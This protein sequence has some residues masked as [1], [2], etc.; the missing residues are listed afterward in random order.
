MDTRRIFVALRIRPLLDNERYEP[1]CVHKADDNQTLIVQQDESSVTTVGSL[2][3]RLDYVFDVN[4][5]QRSVYEDSARDL[6]DHALSGFNSTIFAYGQTGSGKTYTILGNLG[7]NGTVSEQSGVLLRTFNDLFQYKAAVK[8]RM[9]V[10]IT[11]SALELYVED[12][13]DLL[14]SRK[15]LT[16]R[17][18]PEDMYPAGLTTVEVHDLTE[19]VKYFEIANSFRSTASTRM[20]A[21]S[22]RSHAIFF[23]NLF[24]IPNLEDGGGGTALPELS[25]LIDEASFPVANLSFPGL[26]RS[27]IALVDL[28]GS[29]R[30]KRS[31]VQGQ[32]MLEAE[33]INKSL[34]TLGKVVNAMYM[35]SPYVPFRESKLTK[36]L[37]ASFTDNTSRMLLIGQVSP[38]SSSAPESLS[39]VRFC[40]RV[41]SLKLTQ[42]LC[43]GNPEEEESFLRSL[44]QNEE[45]TAEM[46]I[47]AASLYFKPLNLRG[48]A[49]AKGVSVEEERKRVMNELRAGAHDLHERKEKERLEAAKAQVEAERDAELEQFILTMNSQIEEYEQLLHVGK[50]AKKALKRMAE[51]HQAAE[52]DLIHQAKRAKKLRLKLEDHMTGLLAK[53]DEERANEKSLTSMIFEMDTE[54]NTDAETSNV[55]PTDRPGKNLEMEDVMHK[56]ITFYYNRSLELNKLRSHY[57]QRLFATYRERRS[58]RWQKLMSSTLV[59][60]STLLHD[61]LQFVVDRAVDISEG[62][63]RARFG[64]NWEDIDGLSTK[65]RTPEQ[66]YPPLYLT[67]RAHHAEL[68]DAVDEGSLGCSASPAFNSHLDESRSFSVDGETSDGYE[69]MAAIGALQRRGRRQ[70]RSGPLKGL[71]F[72]QKARHP[73]DLRSDSYSQRSNGSGGDKPLDN[74]FHQPHADNFLENNWQTPKKKPTLPGD[75]DVLVDESDSE[76]NAEGESKNSNG[77]LCSPS[78]EKMSKGEHD[79]RY[80]VKVYDSP[81]LVQNL[82]LFLRSGTVMLKHGRS[83]RPHRRLFWVCTSRTQKDLLW[84]DPQL[85]AQSSPSTI[86]LNEV[87]SI[88]LG[89]FSK[90]FQ[91]HPIPPSHPSFF[92][93]FTLELKGGARTVDIV[94]SNLPDYEAWVVGLAHLVGVDPFWGSKLNIT[95]EKGFEQL[96]YFESNLCE[97]HFIFPMDYLT[98][99]NKLIAFTKRTLEVLEQCE[100]DARKAQKILKGIHLPALNSKGALYMT[101]GELRFL[102]PELSL[103]IFRITHI[104]MLFQQMNLVY[105]NNFVPATAFGITKRA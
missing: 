4:D 85:G 76:E 55:P 34:S 43:F 83:G 102:C 38:P 68:Q 16:L 73:S 86:S 56:L 74:G 75:L 7:P 88:Q 103:D 23:I 29:E 1:V 64:W 67:P 98:L 94:A 26:V 78:V 100:G 13:M 28:A 70:H 48:L 50:K 58:V 71:S 63:P 12:V 36:L 101:K 72:N 104:W 17:E 41:K 54:T 19:V 6:V 91:R 30:V 57:V 95:G 92:Y 90:V 60:E 105:D 24:Q 11:L 99:K 3:F 49:I 80:V 2:A 96:S 81:A 22:S 46:R 8:K 45:L 69:Q 44:Q 89:F 40:D 87:S 33:S 52:N 14:A 65:L 51:E 66:L 35:S 25:N 20:N 21:S 18:T 9:H 31:G 32:N 61:I 82:I 27:R 77:K 47:L 97:T 39:T 93:S 62:N 5:D 59:T 10:I 79:R 84:T 42:S 15:K 37:K 53:V